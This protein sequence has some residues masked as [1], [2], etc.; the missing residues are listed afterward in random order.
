[1]WFG[2]SRVQERAG[3]S[4]ERSVTEPPVTGV[5]QPV[6]VN[7]A[8]ADQPAPND[9]RTHPTSAIDALRAA[10]SA[11]EW[12]ASVP[13]PDAVSQ[14]GRL[15]EMTL[16]AERRARRKLT[17][18]GA[19]RGVAGHARAVE[20]AALAMHGFTSYEGFAAIYEPPRSADET[21]SESEATIARI[22]ELLTELGVDPLD[23]PLEA[24]ARV[25]DDARGRPRHSPRL[26][27]RRGERPAPAPVDDANTVAAAAAS[28]LAA[29][30]DTVEPVPGEPFAADPVVSEQVVEHL[31]ITTAMASFAAPPAAA[32]LPEPEAPAAPEPPTVAIPAFRGPRSRTA[33]RGARVDRDGRGR[34]PPR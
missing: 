34:D 10:T 4:D 12:N 29:E 2:R 24:A 18:P 27:R 23:D 32:T 5:G 15:H 13:S 11:A 1:M 14:I 31:D 7:E 22:R 30:P 9:D 16:A 6:P 25:P 8:D 28:W 19:R 26:A 20:A 33:G 21:A 17:T 3:D